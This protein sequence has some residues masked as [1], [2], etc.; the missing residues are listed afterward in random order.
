MP[1]KKVQTPDHQMLDSF[2]CK[3]VCIVLFEALLKYITWFVCI[4]VKYNSTCVMRRESASNNGRSFEK[5]SSLGG[6]GLDKT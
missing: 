6:D 3:T 4:Y 1:H 5:S 2:E